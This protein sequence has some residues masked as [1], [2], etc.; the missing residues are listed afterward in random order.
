MGKL[1]NNDM[2]FIQKT[3]ARFSN[4]FIEQQKNEAI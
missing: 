2:S 4:D 1:I 3:N